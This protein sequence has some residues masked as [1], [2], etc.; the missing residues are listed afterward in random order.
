[1]VNGLILGHNYFRI[2]FIFREAMLMNRVLTNTEVWAPILDEQVGVF[3]D[4]DLMLIRKLIKGH[5][6]AP[7]EAFHMET[8]LLPTKLLCV[9]QEKDHVLTPLNNQT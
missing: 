6:K 9:Y 5:A 8:G 2:A 1:M 4:L 3:E 7:K